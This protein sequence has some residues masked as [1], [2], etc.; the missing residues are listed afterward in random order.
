MPKRTTRRHGTGASTELGSEPD[1]A[2][3]CGANSRAGTQTHHDGEPLSSRAAFQ[4]SQHHAAPLIRHYERPCALAVFKHKRT[5]AIL[6]RHLALQGATVHQHGVRGERPWPSGWGGIAPLGSTARDR[7]QSVT[8]HPQNDVV[9]LTLPVKLLPTPE[10]RAAL[11]DTLHLCNEGANLCSRVV[12]REKKFRQFDIHA[13]V[14]Q[15]LKTLGLGA[16][17][18]IRTIA[19]VADA[20]QLD[21]RTRRKFRAASAQPFD[22]RMLSWNHDAKTVSIWSVRGRRKDIAF[23]GADEH[24]A[25]IAKSR[26]G[27][28][29]LVFRDGELYLHATIDVPEPPTIVPK[30]FLGVD[31]GIVNI[32]TT[33]DGARHAGMHL[34]RV[35][36]RNRHLRQKL[37]KKGT[38]SAKRL[39]KRRSR[40]ES[41]FARD[42]N[43]C[44]S[45]QIVAEA[46]RTGRGIALEDLKGIRER[47][48]SKKP[49]RATLHSWSF[50]QLGAFVSYK[51]QR[52]GI[53]VVFVD[54]A[55]TSQTCSV[56]G[57]IDKRA[58]K[59]Q[60]T[61]QCTNE[62]CGVSLHADE[63]AA[64]NIASR[65]AGRWADVNRPDAGPQASS[66][67][68]P[69]GRAR[70]RTEPAQTDHTFCSPRHLQAHPFR[71]G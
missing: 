62:N 32:A 55:C 42:V 67:D 59:N 7:H 19:K 18:A 34:N 12:W 17:A 33:S 9:K 38:K 69:T 24:L 41:R 4:Q 71:G 13:L 50:A 6:R 37:Q 20:Y 60:A 30:S 8:P 58:R 28:S 27:E 40:K 22:D 44:I 48:R 63:N 66:L 46:Q 16:Q 45:K 2:R 68:G 52:A 57:N 61:Y 39:L 36:H 1:V 35:R 23:V 29:D 43:H 51:A 64:V 11:V 53:P 15:D 49:Q 26:N 10:Q 3:G 47:A 5:A 56:C 70:R 31:L 14:Y 25:Q 21:H 54:P 65:G